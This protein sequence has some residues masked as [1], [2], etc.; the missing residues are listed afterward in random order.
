MGKG[1][2][3][4]FRNMVDEP[5]KLSWFRTHFNIPDDVTLVLAEE[6]AVGEGSP[7]T[8]PFPIQS[9]VEGGIRFPINP[10]F[11][12]FLHHCNLNPMQVSMNLIRVVNGVVELNRRLSLKLGIWEILQ[13]YSVNRHPT[14]TY[15]LRPRGDE[16]FVEGITDSDKHA[17]HFFQVGGNFEYPPEITVRDHP[18]PR[19]FGHPGHRFSIVFAMLILIIIIF[20][21]DL[22]L[23][24]LSYFSF[25]SEGIYS[26]SPRFG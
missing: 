1:K 26:I 2:G 25:C 17:G 20:S 3:K 8:A 11:R 9:I 5:T 24:F 16:V 22:M 4:K 15:F 23:T 12:Q 10:L 14:G 21:V 7:E 13:V 19:Y 18:L 6:G